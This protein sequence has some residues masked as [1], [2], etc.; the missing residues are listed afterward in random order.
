M[1]PIVRQEP[2][3]DWTVTQ[4]FSYLGLWP[5]F[6]SYNILSDSSDILYNILGHIIQERP[7]RGLE[8]TAQRIPSD[9][10]DKYKRKRPNNNNIK[11][12][13]WDF[14][15]KLNAGKPCT[16]HAKEYYRKVL[17]C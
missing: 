12:N 4:T 5:F 13:N 16:R 7:S 11:T 2:V 17:Q 3:R 1:K 15:K 9:D 14:I 8:P 10:E 6:F